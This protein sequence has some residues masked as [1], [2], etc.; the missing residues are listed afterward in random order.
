[1]MA[2]L[3]EIADGTVVPAAAAAAAAAS[4]A[5]GEAPGIVMNSSRPSRGIL[6]AGSPLRM[7]S[8]VPT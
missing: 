4:T 2:I 1:M 5:A 7:A 8:K 3:K 6:L